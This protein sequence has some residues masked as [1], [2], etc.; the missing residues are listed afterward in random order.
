M[1]ISNKDSAQ[2]CRQPRRHKLAL[3]T[4]VGL[5]APVYFVPPAL[6]VLLGGPRLFVVSTAVALIVVLMTYVIMPTLTHF[7]ASWLQEK[8]SIGLKT[9]SRRIKGI[10]Q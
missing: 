9:S 10:E 8:P 7:A 6:E 5:L 2:L 1:Q 4:F 3:L